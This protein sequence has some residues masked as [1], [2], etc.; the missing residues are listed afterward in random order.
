MVFGKVYI[1]TSRLTE[2]CYV[3]ST[4]YPYLSQRFNTHRVDFKNGT[5]DY[6]GLFGYD[7]EG[8]L[9]EPE[10][11]LLEDVKCSTK[12]ELIKREQEWI[13]VYQDLCINK[14]RAYATPEQKKE[15]FDASVKKYHK[16]QKG[17]LSMKKANLRANIKRMHTEIHKEKEEMEKEKAQIDEDMGGYLT[18]CYEGIDSDYKDIYCN[19]LDRQSILERKLKKHNK[20]NDTLNR[21]LIELAQLCPEDPLIKTQK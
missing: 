16:S 15:Q 14:K 3:G 12:E 13:N 7:K 11:K 6:Q 10:I 20:K 8:K 18:M 1:L 19:I 4:T 2:K 21:Y 5:K 17:K 9:I